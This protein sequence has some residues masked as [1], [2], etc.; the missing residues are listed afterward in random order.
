MG[1]VHGI[2]GEVTE[3]P[4]SKRVAWWRNRCPFK[5]ESTTFLADTLIRPVDAAWTPVGSSCAQSRAKRV[6]VDTK[7]EK[8]VV[9]RFL[10]IFVD[11]SEASESAMI[12]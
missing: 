9:S 1:F 2:L 11:I 3:L 10:S 7:T 5:V 12:V 4:R 8:A 6:R